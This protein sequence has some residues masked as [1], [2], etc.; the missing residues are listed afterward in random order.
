MNRQLFHAQL[1]QYAT[2]TVMGEDSLYLSNGVKCHLPYLKVDGNTAVTPKY[3]GYQLFNKDTITFGKNLNADTGELYSFSLRGVSDYIEVDAAKQ[4]T[5]Y[6]PYQAP[7]GYTRYICCYDTDKIFVGAPTVVSGNQL[8]GYATY[9]FTSDVKYIKLNFWYDTENSINESEGLIFYE[10]TGEKSYEP[11]IKGI[12]PPNPDYPQT[13]VNAGGSSENLFTTENVTTGA[14]NNNGAINTNGNYKTTDF[15]EVIPNQQYILDYQIN[16]VWG[17]RKLCAYDSGKKFVRV[18]YHETPHVIKNERF[19]FTIPSK[20]KYIRLQW[21]SNTNIGADTNIKISKYCGV[22]LHGKNLATAQQ[23]CSN[24]PSY[25]ESEFEGRQCI[26]YLQNNSNYFVLEGG[27]KSATQYTISFEGHSVGS[28]NGASAYF[29]YDGIT[30]SNDDV[31]WAGSTTTWSKITKTSRAGKTVKGIGLI[32]ADYRR[33]IYI[34][35]N[36][37]MLQEA[38]VSSQVYEPYWR[39]EI[40]IPASV[41]VDDSTV[42]LLM[43][44]YDSLIVNTK[45]NKVIY[46]EGSW[47]RKVTGYEPWARHNWAYNNGYGTCYILNIGYYFD[48]VPAQN[49]GYCSH[50]PR[51]RYKMPADINSFSVSQGDQIIV[52]CTDRETPVEDFKL[53]LQQK[54]RKG[55]PIVVLIKRL[56]PIEHDIT[57][58]EFGQQLL[59]FLVQRNGT[60]AIAISNNA[61]PQLLTAK[62]LTHSYYKPIETQI[63]DNP[64]EMEVTA[65]DL[66]IYTVTNDSGTELIIN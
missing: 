42:P 16:K 2:P 31:I 19:I 54:D 4:Y 5:I 26:S 28:G 48:A 7:D 32:T 36:T 22:V 29:L 20:A 17:D 62:Y 25:K 34:D 40:A 1:A 63:I 6:R 45:E 39:E 50:F 10:G 65:S 13:I 35:I 12:T 3:Q 49:E 37:F 8:T 33:T 18:L 64:P 15:I 24:F 55:D 27:F 51:T 44:E 11:Y 61:L 57:H 41:E 46:I 14:L 9:S 21:L 47:K 30:P 60:T 53:W 56:T 52:I 58:T 23:V 59:N 66:N 43:S 38:A